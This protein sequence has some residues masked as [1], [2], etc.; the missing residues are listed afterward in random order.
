MSSSTTPGTYR[1]LTRSS[2]IRFL[3]SSE[4]MKASVSGAVTEATDGSLSKAF[5]L[6]DEAF[7]CLVNF[8]REFEKELTFVEKSMEKV[9]GRTRFRRD[10]VEPFDVFERDGVRIV[11]TLQ[12]FWHKAILW[13]V[14]NRVPHEFRDVRGKD[15]IEKPDFR[16]MGGFRY[17]QREITEKALSRGY[18]GMIG[19]PTRWGKSTVLRNIIKAHPNSRWLVVAPGKSLLTQTRDEML[20]V[21][22]DGR[23]VKLL[24]GGGRARFQSGSCNGITICSMDSLHRIDE[25]EID[26]VLVDEPHALMSTSRINHLPRFCLAR[27]YALGATL[28]GRYDG[29]DAMMEGIFGP[30]LAMTTYREAV[31]MGAVCQLKVPLIRLPISAKPG[32][33][34][35]AYRRFILQNE[36]MG[37]IVG[38]LC[39]RLIPREDQTLV[40]VKQENQGRMLQRFVGDEVPLIMD[41]VL[42]GRERNEYTRMVAENHL[43]RVL[44]SDIFVQGVT[45]HEIRYLINTAGGGPSTTALQKPGR[46]AEIRPDKRFGVMVDF[47]FELPRKRAGETRPDG[48][49]GVNSLIREARQRRE[50]Y[51]KTGYQVDEVD[52]DQLEN[53]IKDNNTHEQ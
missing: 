7:T 38:D 42:T 35:A 6:W 18:S 23:E 44:C 8:P 50:V 33:R 53:W 25:F 34:E 14:R 41:K 52:P 4:N 3:S 17:N 29:R 22:G 15:L 46:L 31:S 45:F 39:R 32:N 19:A 43:S 11:L 12:G 48:M 20:E 36:L 1:R 47:M 28:T 26:G 13:A 9:R 10:P 27:K 21:F 5:I 24:G 16:L 30:V 40:F 2:C 37:R 51:E 49:N